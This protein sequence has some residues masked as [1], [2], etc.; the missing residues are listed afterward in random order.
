MYYYVTPNC[1]E[2]DEGKEILNGVP[3]KE[4]QVDSDPFVAQGIR[5]V[6]GKVIVPLLVEGNGT[7]KVLAEFDGMKRFVRVL[8]R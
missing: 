4:I 2:C 7:I 6:M 8:S 1:K 3:Y 5:S